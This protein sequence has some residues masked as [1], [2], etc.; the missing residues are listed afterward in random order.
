LRIPRD[1]TGG[2]TMLLS[3]AELDEETDDGSEELAEAEG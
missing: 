3:E 2:D 1:G